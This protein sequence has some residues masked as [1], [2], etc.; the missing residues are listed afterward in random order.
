MKDDDAKDMMKFTAAYDA[1]AGGFP[2]TP[3]EKLID[4]KELNHAF[5]IQD[6]D[7]DAKSQ[8]EHIADT[9]HD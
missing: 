5:G 7:V 6:S 9:Y 4:Y 2:E 8:F 3:S 1:L